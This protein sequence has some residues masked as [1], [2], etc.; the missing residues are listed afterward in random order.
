MF[1]CCCENRR[2]NRLQFSTNTHDEL[3]YTVTIPPRFI[4][5]NRSIVELASP[6]DTEFRSDN[7]ACGLFVRRHPSLYKKETKLFVAREQSQTP[8]NSVREEYRSQTTLAF[9]SETM[10]EPAVSSEEF[11][12]IKKNEKL[13]QQ[14]PHNIRKINCTPIKK[15]LIKCPLSNSDVVSGECDHN[16]GLLS[17]KYGDI[18][19]TVPKGAIQD[20]QLVTFYIAT[21]LYSGQFKLPSQTQTDIVSP[22]YWIGVT[23]SNHFQKPIQVEFEHFAVVTACDPS[24]FQL[25]SCEDDDESYTM[26]SSGYEVKFKL[27][28]DISLCTFETYHFCSYCLHCSCKDPRINRISALYLKP[29]SYQYLHKYTVQI[30]FSFPIS[31]CLKR[32]KKLYTKKNMILDSDHGYIFE[33]SCNKRSKSYFTLTYVDNVGHWNI[34]HSLSLTIPTKKVNFYNYYGKEKELRASE[35]NSFSHHV[36]LLM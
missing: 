34:R 15:F 22:Y 35:K 12:Q 18:K 24:H 1:S 2:R 14:S 3:E 4:R 10:L 13:G 33:V 7:A 17:S 21:D 29:Q 11:S 19:I 20:K 8:L 5:R 28:D 9:T 32:N 23:K 6:S 31:Q 25:L 30:W 27:Q 36:L 16:G 26:Q